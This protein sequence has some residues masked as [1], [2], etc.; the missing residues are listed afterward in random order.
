MKKTPLY[1]LLTALAGAL[2]AFAPLP[3]QDAA[4]RQLTFR[5]EASQFTYL[6][7]EINVNP[8]DMVTIELVS[9]DVVHGF[10]LDGYGVSMTADPGQTAR[11]TFV[12]SQ[13]GSFRFRC[14]VTCGAMHPFM[15]GKFNVGANTS[16]WRAV[17]LVLVTAVAMFGFISHPPAEK[18]A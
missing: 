2:I 12:A 18:E 5:L 4:P 10:Y 11:L 13:P 3:I 6:P 14:N 7:A 1:A 17:G 16:L 15:I 8:G 9:M